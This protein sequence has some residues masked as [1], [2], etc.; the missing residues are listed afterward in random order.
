MAGVLVLLMYAALFAAPLWAIAVVVKL[1][2][3]ILPGRRPDWGR[4]LLRWCAGMAAA[5]VVIT[6]AFGVGAIQ[7][8]VNEA[9]SGA[10]SLPATPCRS[11]PPGVLA[12]VAGHEPSY[13]PLGFDC[14]LTDGSVAAGDGDSYTSL[15]TMVVAL[16]LAAVLALIA[17]GCLDEHRARTGR[18][19]GRGGEDPVEGEGT[20][21]LSV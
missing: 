17:V 16:A 5:G 7:A 14:L 21:G 1:V 6:Y 15:N 12:Q 10:S 13:V 18:R 2:S 19:A 9:S 4:D 11:L 20:G 8:A 3:V